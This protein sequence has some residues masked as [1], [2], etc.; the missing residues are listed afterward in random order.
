MCSTSF[1]PIGMSK[2]IHRG[3]GMYTNETNKF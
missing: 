3:Y 1:D 2:K